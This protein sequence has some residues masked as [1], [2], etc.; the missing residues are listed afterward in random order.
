MTSTIRLRKA[1]FR[2][3]NYV[4]LTSRSHALSQLTEDG[5]PIGASDVLGR[6]RGG[7]AE[8]VSLH[9]QRSKVTWKWMA[10]LSAVP[11]TRVVTSPD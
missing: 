3:C 11:H 5:Y 6:L 10:L 4:N 8:V 2:C 9:V 1:P 7:G